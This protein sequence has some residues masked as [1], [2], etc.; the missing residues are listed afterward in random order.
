MSRNPLPESVSKCSARERGISN[1]TKLTKGL[2][3][4][5]EAAFRQF[6][7]LYFDRLLRYL[8]VITRGDE[9][10]ARD[11]LQETFLRVARHARRFDDEDAFWKWLTVLARSAAV[12]GGRKQWRYWRLLANYARSWLAP[13]ASHHPAEDAERSLEPLLEQGLSR[14]DE[15][16][17]EL[18]EEKYFQGASVKELSR[19]T[20]LSEKAVESRLLRARHRLREDMI[21]Q[22]QNENIV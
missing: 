18:I 14:L 15:R 10:A 13:G 20:G 4:G 22:M 3:A 7:A 1:I 19:R 12:D 21:K 16:D 9:D 6:H 5:N 8:L 17:R 2:G 11:A